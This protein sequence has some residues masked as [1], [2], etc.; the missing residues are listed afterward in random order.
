MFVFKLLIFSAG[1]YN[2]EESHT[3]FQTLWNR[4][5]EKNTYKKW[6]CEKEIH[7]VCHKSWLGRIKQKVSREKSPLEWSVSVFSFELYRISK[8]KH[9]TCFGIS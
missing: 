3:P 6:K 4:L 7:N 2:S 1:I 9:S 5:L 8:I